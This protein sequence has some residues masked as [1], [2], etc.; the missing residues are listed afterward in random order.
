MFRTVDYRLL[1]KELDRL[2]EIV[3]KINEELSIMQQNASNLNI[4]WDGE[5][6]AEFI[7][8][9]N[10]SIYDARLLLEKLKKCN[11]FL[12]YALSR[13]QSSEMKI[14]EIISEATM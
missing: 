14:S 2:S 11:S 9:F 12:S 8:N 4:Y 1:S 3:I 6:N 13:Y 10:A 5:A 7:L